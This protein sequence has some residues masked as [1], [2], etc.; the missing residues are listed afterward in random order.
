MLSH[1]VG[2]FP[3]PCYN[4]FRLDNDSQKKISLAPFAVRADRFPTHVPVVLCSDEQNEK[5]YSMA[6][7]M[8]VMRGM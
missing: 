3:A 1:K 8:G 4:F 7:V 5:A 2:F 6:P